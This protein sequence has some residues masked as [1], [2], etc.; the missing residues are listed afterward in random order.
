MH[1]FKRMQL[2]STCYRKWWS[3]LLPIPILDGGHILFFTVEALSRRPV[4]LRFREIASYVGLF[5]I[6]FLMV[7]AFKNDI[8]RY[9]D[10]FMGVFK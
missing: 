8:E 6:L 10:D 1:P 4:S 7:L 3:N 9:W 2:S 5:M